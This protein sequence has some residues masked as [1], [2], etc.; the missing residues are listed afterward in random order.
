MS[1]AAHWQSTVD[2]ITQNPGQTFPELG[3]HSPWMFG[4]GVELTLP[5]HNVLL[6]HDLSEE[7]AR[8]FQHASIRQAVVPRVVGLA[9]YAWGGVMPDLPVAVRLPR[10]GY[11]ALRWAPVAFDPRASAGPAGFVAARVVF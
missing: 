3:E 10:G 9:Q 4:G 11:K 1:I 2:H 8:F 7:G 6:W 5:D